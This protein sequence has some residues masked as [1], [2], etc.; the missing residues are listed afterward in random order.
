MFQLFPNDTYDTDPATPRR[1]MDRLFLGSRWYFAVG[2]YLEILRARRVA[3]KNLYND[4]AWSQSSN[5]IVKLIEGCGGRLHL[6]GIDNVG[7]LKEPV[8]FISNH[9][10]ML[11]TFVFP[12]IIAPLRPVTYVVKESLVKHSAFGPVMRSRNPIVV[13]R[14]NAREDLTIVLEKGQELLRSGTSIIIFPQSTR[15]EIFDPR[16]FNTLGII[17]ARKAGVQVI[18]VAIKTDFWGNG[19]IFRD[20]GP[21]HR[22]KPIYMHFD[23]SFPIVGSGKTEH[24]KILEFIKERLLFWGGRIRT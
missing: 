21:V 17:L 13:L 7:S 8:V 3:I 6:S 18:P 15:S 1:F 12:S 14:K 4:E 19:S 2:Y 5:R 10:S 16:T 9:M 22:E 24:L 23:S 11:E 20:V